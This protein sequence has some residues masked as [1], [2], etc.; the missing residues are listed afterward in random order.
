MADNITDDHRSHS[1]DAILIV[2]FGG[3]EG[4]NDVMPFLDNVLAGLKVPTRVK[5]PVSY[6]HLRAHETDS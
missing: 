5:K 6:T 4:P 2:S 3:P 1:Y